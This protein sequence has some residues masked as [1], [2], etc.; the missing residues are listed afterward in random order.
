M[1]DV[2]EIK[3]EFENKIKLIEESDQRKNNFIYKIMN[4]SFVL[5]FLIVLS[6]TVLS[7]LNYQKTIKN[8]ANV[9]NN[10]NVIEFKK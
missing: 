10:S 6:G 9:S 8:Q 4:A 1:N 3:Q 7:F 2:S 5:L